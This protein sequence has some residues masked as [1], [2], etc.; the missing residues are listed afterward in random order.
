MTYKGEQRGRRTH[1]CDW[2]FETVDTVQNGDPRVCSWSE[3]MCCTPRHSLAI[4]CH[5]AAAQMEARVRVRVTGNA[6]VGTYRYNTLHSP[7]SRSSHRCTRVNPLHPP[8]SVLRIGESCIC[9]PTGDRGDRLCGGWRTG[10]GLVPS[11]I[12]RLV[13]VSLRFFSSWGWGGRHLHFIIP[14]R[15]TEASRRSS[16]SFASPFA[17]SLPPLP[18]PPGPVPSSISAASTAPSNSWLVSLPSLLSL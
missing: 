5:M 6:G 7:S 2:D 8:L 4:S 3:Y 16:H 13:W 17:P 14:R 15:T 10:R 12:R 11:P 9:L 1:E 18:R